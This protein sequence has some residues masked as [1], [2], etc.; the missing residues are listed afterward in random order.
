MIGEGSHKK[1]VQEKL[2]VFVNALAWSGRRGGVAWVSFARSG[3]V[4]ERPVSAVVLVADDE[5]DGGEQGR[6]K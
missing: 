2:S 1:P 5:V 4:N 3:I 6:E